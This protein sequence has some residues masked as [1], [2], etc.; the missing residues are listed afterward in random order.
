MTEARFE[1][2]TDAQW[3]ILQPLLPKEPAKRGKGSPHAP[4]RQVCNTILWVLITGSRWCDVP[5]G[6]QWGSRPGAHRWLGR[7]QEDNT[8]EGLLHALLEMAELAGLLDWE[9]LAADGFFSAGKGGGEE[10]AYGFKGKGTTTH[11][12]V[13]GNGSPVAFVSTAANGDERQQVE[14]LIDRV[15]VCVDRWRERF[16]SFTIFEADK[17]YDANTLREKL[18][19]RKIFPWICRRRKPGQVGEKIESV[20]KRARWKVERAIS[21]LQRKFRRLAVR[22]E[23][24]T[25]Y[26]KGFL[27]F[28]LVVFW[29]NRLVR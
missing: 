3:K 22:W 18:L 2:L 27:T 21:W 15:Q 10:I 12:L 16:E 5:K 23:R 20:L 1:G 14:P 7:W 24:R 6:T 13:D 9:R 8:L 29:I 11:L 28:G 26:W 4:W 25:R 19:T 17:G